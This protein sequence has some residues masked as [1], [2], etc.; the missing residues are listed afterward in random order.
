MTKG[1]KFHLFDLWRDDVGAALVEFTLLA[2]FL[3]FLGLGM[4]EF[5]RFLYQYQLVLDG[6]RDGAR[7]L[8]R[9]EDPTD[10]TNQSNAANLAVTGTIDGTGAAR[11]DGWT[12]ADLVFV[13]GDL[14]VDNS[15]GTYRGDDIIQRV[16][17]TTTFDYDDVGFLSALGLPALS[18]D[19]T[20]MQRAI[21]E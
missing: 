7:Y 21:R 9:L 6:L 16:Q 8:A 18:V 10:A 5:G 17:A 19:A 14:D 3:L 4:A 15:D 2:P 11:V 1:R 20:H 13:V 12:A